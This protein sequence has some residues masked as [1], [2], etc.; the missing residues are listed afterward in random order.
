MTERYQPYSSHGCRNKRV[1]E[2]ITQDNI[3][4]KKKQKTWNKTYTIPSGQR[5]YSRPKT[6]LEGE[7]YD[8]WIVKRWWKSSLYTVKNYCNECHGNKCMVTWISPINLIYLRKTRRSHQYETEVHHMATR[9]FSW[10]P[11][12]NQKQFTICIVANSLL[13][14]RVCLLRNIFNKFRRK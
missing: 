7:A 11:W 3:S 13:V 2:E 8:Q 12:G 14:H 1:R 10:L 5:D 9:C 4:V 6:P